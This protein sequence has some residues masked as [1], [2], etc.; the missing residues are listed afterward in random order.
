[1]KLARMLQI[2]RQMVALPGRASRTEK[3]RMG[4]F[5]TEFRRFLAIEELE[6]RRVQDSGSLV[7]TVEAGTGPGTLYS[8]IELANV[9]PGPNRIEFSQEVTTVRPSATLPSINEALV[10]DGGGR[11]TIDGAGS[12]GNGLVIKGSDVSIKNISIG[13]F[14]SGTGIL[15]QGAGKGKVQGVKIGT[16]L[17]GSLA[18]PNNYGIE[19]DGSSNI[20]IGIDGD[21]QGDVDEANVISGNKREAIVVKGDKSIGTLIAGNFIGTDA[22][23]EAAIPNGEGVWISSGS[24]STLVRGNTISGNVGSG[25]N[26]SSAKDSVVEGN[27]IGLNA[28]GTAK[29]ANMGNAGLV[30]YGNAQNTRIGTDGNGIGDVAERNIISGN[31]QEGIQIEASDNTVVA[32]NYIGTNF[33]GSKALPNSSSGIHIWRSP[34]R[35]RI[36]TDNSNDPFNVNERNLISGNSSNGITVTQSAK[37]T[38]ISG[39]WIGTDATGANAIPNSY[40]GLWVGGGSISTRI[41]RNTISGNTGSGIGIANTNGTIV[42]GNIIGLNANGT[43][44]LANM[45]N[46]GVVVYGGAQNTRIGTDG[47]GVDDSLE[48]NTISGNAQEGIQIEASDKTVVAGNYIGTNFEGTIAIPNTYSG[49]LLWNAPTNARIGT[50]GSEDAFNSNERNLISGNNSNGITIRQSSS[51]TTVAGNWIG[52]NANGTGA[53]PNIGHGIEVYENAIRTVIGTNGDGHGD[54]DERNII[55]GNI[56]GIS[57]SGSNATPTTIAGNYIGTNAAGIAAIG[58]SQDGIWIVN[59]ASTRIGTNGDGTS[60]A[61]ERNIISGNFWNGIQITGLSATNNIVAGNYIGTNASGTAALAN[62]S[63]GVRISGGASTNLI[64]TNG[65]GVSDTAES[66]LIS[67]NLI[68]GVSVQDAATANNR[69]AGNF[70]GTNATGT[71][72]IANIYAGIAV[73]AS[74]SG[75][76]LGTNSSSDNFNANERNVLSGNGRQGIYIT[77]AT[78]TTI[79]GNSI[80]L[81][82]NGTD[83]LGNGWQGVLLHPGSVRTRIGTNGDG[84]YDETERNIVS[85]NG[86]EG[87]AVVGAGT[88]ETTISGNYIGVDATGSLD[89]GNALS[90]VAVYSGASNTIVG[91]SSPLYGNLLAGNLIG[92]RLDVPAI[93]VSESRHNRFYDNA[94]VAIDLGP[95]GSTPN[96]EGDTDGVRNAPVITEVRL[97]NDS[98]VIEGFARPG[99]SIDFYK[100]RSYASGF[101]QGETYLKSVVEGG[102]QDQDNSLGS[103]N[104]SSVGGIAIGSDTTNRF[105]FVLPLSE[106]QNSITG[107]ERITAVAINPTSEFGNQAVVSREIYL[108]GT[109]ITENADTNAT[110]GT[111]TTAAPDAAN[112]FTYTLVS[113]T[114]DTDNAAFNIDGDKLRANSSFDF[115]TRSSY[116]LR[117]RSTDQNGLRT[118]KVFAISVTDVNETPIPP[119]FGSIVFSDDFSNG[120]TQWTGQNQGSHHAV[121][122]SDPLSSGR[123]GVVT[124]NQLNSAG[125]IFSIPVIESG[126]TTKNWTVSFDY[127]GIPGRG[128]VDSDLGG[129]VGVTTQ[130]HDGYWI[131]GTSPS[132]PTWT[133]LIDDNSWRRYS[134]SYSWNFDHRLMLEDWSGSNG[135]AGDAM[136]DNIVLTS[137]TLVG[138]IPENAPID[139]AIATL[140]TRDPDNSNTFSYSLVSGVG[141]TDNADFAISGNQLIAKR[142]FDF[143]A[144][145]TYS[146]RVRSTDQGGLSADRVL[147]VSITDINETPTNIS[148][149]ATSIAENTGA[150]ATVGSFTT[151]DPDAA[152][153][154]AYTLV[155]GTGDTDNAAFNIDGDTLRASSSFDYESKSSYSVRVRSTDQGGLWTEKVFTI[156]VTDVNETPTNI[157]LSANSIA[158]NSGAYATVGTLTTTDPD[159]ANTFTYTLVSGTGD[160]DNASFNI[161][162][163]A[164]RASSSFDFETKSSYSVRVRSTDQGGLYTEKVFTINVINTN[165]LVS[166]SVNGADNFINARQRSQIT[167]VVVVTESVLSDPQTAFSLTN[168]GL[169]TASSSSLASSQILVTSVGNVYTLRF[170][171]G[172]GV[173]AREGTGARANSLADGN[174]I[175]TVAGSEVSGT[176]QFGNRAVDNFFRMFGDSDG[177]GDVDGTDAV[178]LR[179]AQIAASYNAALDW[180]GNGSV[181]SGADINYFSL[182]QNKR[183]RLF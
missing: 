74:A 8:M 66:N 47:N 52:L 78:N 49:I 126:G 85:S 90:G 36:G 39:N 41:R 136:F 40:D 120:L 76:I 175:L 3:V 147:T 121:I 72:S 167:S 20:T 140:W 101:G 142:T 159:T 174:W 180:D 179:K 23:G 60:D 93:N 183:R 143:E 113:G 106:L 173:V 172:A 146:I 134:I 45:G 6:Y 83:S 182:N 130:F 156:S 119:F 103:Y 79:A 59:T 94:L 128:G 155:S 7:V 109:T 116:S 63:S 12:P 4:G 81:A 102:D 132:W 144:K 42:D 61:A 124:F 73:F 29:I 14:A 57:V 16:N 22:T 84:N 89:R 150:D 171:A 24:S 95:S 131:A 112:T 100:T 35:A 111:L 158:E 176:N 31:T 58:N 2:L 71:V 10:I 148:L 9:Q 91:G 86:Y 56:R 135:V 26:I 166:V 87:I 34:T 98:L 139:T 149:S 127:L 62:S 68:D 32:G 13:G 169:L 82:A 19:V 97:S 70:I 17:S 51:D 75:T 77:N 170:G 64:G 92:I 15:F 107:G 163:N 161:S 28:K 38:T 157:N 177:D 145:P 1:M 168:I 108:S 104:S 88:T 105:R 118:E 164:L 65:D 43:A 30:I 55:S 165:E 123:E 162:G 115:E 114:G 80:G 11:I 37:D 153:T 137:N 96:D 21:G 99:T 33:D 129:F 138:R 125:D 133:N 154:F 46:A 54:M 53:I 18:T 44:K 48:R 69:I 122:V 152:N 141:D 117:V 151:I 181:T 67:G 5:W 50:D 25:M 160:T 27:I 178:A 110:I